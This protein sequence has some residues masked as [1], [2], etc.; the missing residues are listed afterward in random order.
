VRTARMA[1]FSMAARVLVRT[2][3]CSAYWWV[4]DQ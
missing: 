2:S 3:N 1:S 4:D